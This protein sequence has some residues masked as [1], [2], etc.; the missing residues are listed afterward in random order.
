MLE[1]QGFLHMQ[2]DFLSWEW[3]RKTSLSKQGE[4]AKM[5]RWSFLG[6]NGAQSQWAQIWL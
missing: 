6:S 3:E 4:R 5:E 2:E 1:D